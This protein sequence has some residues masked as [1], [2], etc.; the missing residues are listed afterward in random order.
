M[1]TGEKRLF[2]SLLETER[3]A[4]T[5]LACEELQGRRGTI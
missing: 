5:V 2:D 1:A 4:F 3:R